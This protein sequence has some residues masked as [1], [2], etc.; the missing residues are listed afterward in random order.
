MKI[1]D[2]LSVVDTENGSEKRNRRGVPT[3]ENYSSA[4]ETSFEN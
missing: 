1:T 3:T 4:E 2:Y